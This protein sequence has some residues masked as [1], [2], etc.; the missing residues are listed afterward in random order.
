LFG[1]IEEISTGIKEAI[2]TIFIAAIALIPSNKL[3]MHYCYVATR[4]STWI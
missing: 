4:I 1:G 3:L 2:A